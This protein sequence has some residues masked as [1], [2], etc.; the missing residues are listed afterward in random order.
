MFPRKHRKLLY[1]DSS[2][3]IDCKSFSVIFITLRSMTGINKTKQANVRRL[4]F[5]QSKIAQLSEAASGIL[6]IFLERIQKYDVSELQNKFKK[7]NMEG[8]IKILQNCSMK[9]SMYVL[10]YLYNN[11]LPALLQFC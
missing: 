7:S 8:I 6:I 9:K 1:E 5:F 3:K 4:N 2:V 11:P 10:L